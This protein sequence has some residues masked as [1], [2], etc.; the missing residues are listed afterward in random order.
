MGVRG[1]AGR[2]LREEEEEEG[3]VFSFLGIFQFS[4]LFL[5]LLLFSFPS[6]AAVNRTKN[7]FSHSRFKTRDLC[8]STAAAAAA[9]S[10]SSSASAA[11]GQ[12][13]LDSFLDEYVRLRS[14]FHERELKQQAAEQTLL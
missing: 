12:R 7:F 5:Q 9:S 8:L 1:A 2:G 3:G 11:A 13:A 14:K 4:S 10:P 6:S